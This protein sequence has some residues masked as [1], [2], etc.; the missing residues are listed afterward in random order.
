MQLVVHAMHC[1]NTFANVQKL[2][3]YYIWLQLFRQQT[4]YISICQQLFWTFH[5]FHFF[6]LPIFALFSLISCTFTTLSLG[7][8][9]INLFIKPTLYCSAT[10]Y[11]CASAGWPTTVYTATL[12][13]I[14]NVTSHNLLSA[15]I[16]K[17]SN[18]AALWK[19]VC[20]REAS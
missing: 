2:F 1:H 20:D 8:S 10:L 7:G 9:R 19:R 12:M 15:R 16:E 5:N 17:H 3:T 18:N 4:F 6:Q 13:H 14:R 11:I